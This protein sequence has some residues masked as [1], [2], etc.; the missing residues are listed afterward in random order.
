MMALKKNFNNLFKTLINYKK[1]S[2]FKINKQS[3]KL[4]R[5]ECLKAP[6][7]H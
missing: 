4:T 6:F 1:R 2:K 3:L 7:Q 5:K